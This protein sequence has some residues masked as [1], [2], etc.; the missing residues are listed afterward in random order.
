MLPADK[1]DAVLAELRRRSGLSPSREIEDVYPCTRLQ[2]GLIALSEKQPGSY[3]AKYIYKVPEYVDIDRFKEAWARTLAT[4]ANLRARIIPFGGS[5]YQAI[6][7]EGANWESTDGHN[8]HSFLKAAGETIMGYG[9][10]LCRYAL[11]TDDNGEKYLVWIMHHA[12]FDGWTMNIVI[13]VLQREYSGLEKPAMQP[14]S[15]FI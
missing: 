11:V 9:D 15:G 12:I 13:D 10:R 6:I 3:V 5:T 4:C 2:E 14:Y 7:K 8:V 1:V